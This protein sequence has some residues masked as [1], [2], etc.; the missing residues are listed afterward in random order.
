MDGRDQSAP[1]VMAQNKPQAD[2]ILTGDFP[3]RDTHFGYN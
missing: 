1:I 3:M 2:C